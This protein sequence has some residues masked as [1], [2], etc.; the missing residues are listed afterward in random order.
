MFVVT[1]IIEAGTSQNHLGWPR[2]SYR[3][4]SKEEDEEPDRGNDEKTTSKSGLA[5]VPLAHDMLHVIS[6]RCVARDLHW[7]LDCSS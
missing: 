5:F 2:L 1:L 6:A 7:P 3:E 4:Q